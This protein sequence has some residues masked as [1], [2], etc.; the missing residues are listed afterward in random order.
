MCVDHCIACSAS[1]HSRRYNSKWEYDHAILSHE[2]FMISKRFPHYCWYMN[3]SVVCGYNVQ[4]ASYAW[5]KLWNKQS[6]YRW[7]ETKKPLILCKCKES[8]TI[9]FH[10]CCIHRWIHFSSVSSLCFLITINDLLYHNDDDYI[11]VVYV[12][13]YMF[14]TAHLG[15][16][17][18]WNFGN[19]PPGCFCP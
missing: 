2:D 9:S 15:F 18:L 12:H 1:G 4:K 19:T 11:R 17:E 6:N 5:N 16:L 7:F 14:W 8:L 10:T 3:P 13:Y